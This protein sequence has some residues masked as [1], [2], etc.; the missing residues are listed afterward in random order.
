[1]RGEK[2][3]VEGRTQGVRRVLLL[4]GV[5]L[6]V[7]LLWAHLASGWRAIAPP[8]SHLSVDMPKLPKQQVVESY[9]G[10]YTTFGAS[11]FREDYLVGFCDLSKGGLSGNSDQAVL[12]TM[13]QDRILVKELGEVRK[14]TALSASVPAMECRFEWRKPQGAVYTVIKRVYVARELSRGY[15]VIYAVHEKT[16]TDHVKDRDRFLASFKILSGRTSEDSAT[17]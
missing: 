11:R 8:G 3:D 10:S 2:K 5:V 6:F 17:R 4:C 9:G 1:M 13:L 16:A 7:A 12:R 15:V 14:G